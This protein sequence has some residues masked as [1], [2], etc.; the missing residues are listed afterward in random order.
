M[1]SIITYAVFL[2]VT[3]GGGLLIG[4]QTDTGSWYQSLNKPSFTPPNWLFPL[5]WTILYVLIAIAGARTFMRAP[6]GAAMTIWVV[7]L[8]LNFAWTPV[9]FMAHRPSL[10]LIV[11]GLLLV[12]II[13]FIVVSWVPDRVAALLFAPYAI[14]VGYATALN[15][16]IASNN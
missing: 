4:S 3:L 5:A 2:L 11:I 7:A 13:A 9:F 15:A 10:A 16:T 8:I 1:S 14:W 12:A 6:T